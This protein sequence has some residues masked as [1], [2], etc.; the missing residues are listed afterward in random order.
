MKRKYIYRNRAYATNIP[1]EVAEVLKLDQ[2]GELQ[3]SISKK[4]VVTVKK[5]E[6]EEGK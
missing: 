2:V 5:V 6:V 4:S 3:W 1:K